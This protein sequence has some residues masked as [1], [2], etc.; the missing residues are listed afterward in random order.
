MKAIMGNKCF[1]LI[2]LVLAALLVMAAPVW[3]A[4]IEAKNS[5][6]HVVEKQDKYKDAIEKVGF[7]GG[8]KDGLLTIINEKTYRKQTYLASEKMIVMHEDLE[9]TLDKILDLSI[10]KMIII[11][12]EVVEIVLLVETS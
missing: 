3:S 2:L 4:K 5:K 6:H 11:D 12:A 8:I 1:S 9:I 7:Y 10:V